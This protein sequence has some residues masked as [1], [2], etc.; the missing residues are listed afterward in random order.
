MLRSLILKIIPSSFSKRIASL[1]LILAFFTMSINVIVTIFY[2]YST[3]YENSLSAIESQ[4]TIMSKDI[5][6]AIITEDIYRLYTMVEEVSNNI[7]HIDNIII[8]DENKSYITDAKV[9]KAP[10]EK[11][12]R[13]VKIEKE[14]YVGGHRTVGFIDFYISRE[15]ILKNVLINV[16]L[17]VMINFVVLFVGTISG[18]YF[19]K[20]LTRPMILLSEQLAKMDV[21]RLP[22]KIKL[23]DYSSVE[24]QGLKK[25]IEDLSEDL[26]ESL[27]KIHMQQKDISR[28][29]RLAY[30]G[31]MSAGL[32]HELKNPI[33]SINLILESLA[34]DYKHD[35][36]FQEDYRIIKAQADKLVTRINEFLQYS[37]PINLKN[38]ADNL[39]DI[40]AEI[41]R[42]SYSMKLSGLDI[43]TNADKD[44]QLNIDRDK[45]IQI[46]EILLNNSKEAG[47]DKVILEFSDSDQ[48][49]HVSYSD[50]GSGFSET[51]LSKIMLPFYSTKKEGSGLGLAICSTIMDS[52]GG[53]IS[54]ENCNK[55]GACFKMSIPFDNQQP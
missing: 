37:K 52:M 18:M 6:E 12:D 33:M 28:A 47:A 46:F 31:T 19:S 30:I 45:F 38:K 20:K 39:F 50:N 5:S 11:S 43:V 10:P 22:Y 32:A 8:F 9:R 15:S 17:L 29:E 27:D 55:G 23:P 21:L 40:I 14:L 53:T 51:D 48:T 35:H 34:A 54:A 16:R 7:S 24:T 13:F 1:I 4:F 49:L 44:V 2:E 42:Q 3:T 41:K 36:Q 26:K 25:V